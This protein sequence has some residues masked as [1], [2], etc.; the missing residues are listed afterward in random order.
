MDL[1]AHQLNSSLIG[2]QPEKKLVL[3]LS[4]LFFLFTSRIWFSWDSSSLV[5]ME[6]GL[7]GFF[8][9]NSWSV[10]GFRTYQ[11]GKQGNLS[12]SVP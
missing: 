4:I 8:R 3:L 7:L 6:A 1:W 11:K 5:S 9:S 12:G 2:V 10:M